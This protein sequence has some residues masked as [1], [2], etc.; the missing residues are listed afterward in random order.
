MVALVVILAAV[1]GAIVF[2]L[3]GNIQKGRIVAATADSVGDGISF[4]Y[5]GGQ[6][7]SQ[8][9]NLTVNI[10]GSYAGNLNTTVGSSG[11]AHNIS[12]GSHHVNVIA[13]F[14][15]GIK[16]VILDTNVY[17]GNSTSI[18][19]TVTPTPTVVPPPICVNAEMNWDGSFVLLHFNKSLSSLPPSPSGFTVTVGGSGDTV[20]GV[21]LISPDT[22]GL[23]M[24]G[25]LSPPQVADVVY[26]PGSITSTDGGVLAGFSTTAVWT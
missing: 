22:I 13:E 23:V 20:N 18:T 14:N 3:A 12:A 19:T 9:S 21:N 17:S 11:T 24:D 16:Q 8:V 7:A 2:G 10:D 6:D 4:T 26:T 5:N 15:D 1:I 25:P